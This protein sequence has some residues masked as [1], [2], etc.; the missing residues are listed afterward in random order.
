MVVLSP[1][2]HVLLLVSR[3]QWHNFRLTLWQSRKSVLGIPPLMSVSMQWTFIENLRPVGTERAWSQSS[4]QPISLH[5]PQAS[6]L[7]STGATVNRENSCQSDSSGFLDDPLEPLPL[8]VEGHWRVGR[9]VKAKINRKHTTL[10]H[11]ERT[12]SPSKICTTGTQ[13]RGDWSPTK[14][15]EGLVFLSFVFSFD[16]TKQGSWDS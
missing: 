2:F 5:W 6:W 13:G 16:F 8:Q 10:P 7:L 1:L 15:P 11:L 9:G 14:V 3:N 12:T 4:W